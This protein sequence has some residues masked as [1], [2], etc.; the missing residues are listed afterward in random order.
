MSCACLA[1]PSGTPVLAISFG[2]IG[3][4]FPAD[5]GIFVQIGVSMTPGWTVLTL[6][7]SPA[8]VHSIATAFVNQ[9]H[10]SLHG[11]VTGQTR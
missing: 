9:T 5:A 7:L 8:A 2:S 6:I 4:L 3:A 10:T 1:L 11:A